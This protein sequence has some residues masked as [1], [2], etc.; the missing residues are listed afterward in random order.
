MDKLIITACLSEV[1]LLKNLSALF[2]EATRS[3]A[4]ILDLINFSVLTIAGTP[5]ESV[6]RHYPH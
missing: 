4:I 6:I 5:R 2:I 3:K 1:P